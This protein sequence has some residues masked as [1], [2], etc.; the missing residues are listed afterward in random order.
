MNLRAVAAQSSNETQV[1]ARPPSRQWATRLLRSK[2]DSDKLESGTRSD[3]TGGNGA[4]EEERALAGEQ[5][6]D[7]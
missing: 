7:D 3:N 2:L 4:A 6:V 5:L 1:C